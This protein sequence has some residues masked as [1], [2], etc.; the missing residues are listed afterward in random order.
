MAIHQTAIVSDKAKISPDA[1]IGPYVVI[2]GEVD[3]AEGVIIDHFTT[4]GAE[5]TKVTIG[6][7]T[8]IF[9]GAVV[10]EAP[11][12]LKYKGEKTQV[13]I[14]ENNMIREYVT[15]HAGTPDGGG[16]TQIGNNGL[17][18]AYVHIAHDCVIGD[19]V[20]IA[21]SSQLAGHV[22]I[23]DHVKIGG[24]CAFNQFVRLG[25]YCYIA[26]DSAVNK[27]VLPFAIAQGKYAVMRA[28]NQ[29]GME[30]AGYEKEEVENVRRAL[31]IFTKGG[32][33]VDEA[34]QRIESE[35]G[36]FPSITELL[37]FAQK[38]QRGLAL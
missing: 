15:I 27:D 32:H 23:E 20:V 7:G 13:T 22:I 35:C 36:N 17:F 16:H 34:M 21:N 9:P 37:K 10:G 30:R 29:I 33:T 6:A 8:R 4:I 28:A 3:I 24:V 18:M 19:S 14:G 5:Y 2:R 1:T 12:D 31:R 25:K 26:G 11:Q 38:S